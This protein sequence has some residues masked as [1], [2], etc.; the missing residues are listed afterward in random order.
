MLSGFATLTLIDEMNLYSILPLLLSLGISMTIIF[1]RVRD[2][3]VPLWFGKQYMRWCGIAI[4][5]L[6]LF[7][8]A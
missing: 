4:F 8:Y 7:G 1:G 2:L 6:L 3:T 5:F